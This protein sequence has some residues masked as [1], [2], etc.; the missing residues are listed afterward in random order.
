VTTTPRIYDAAVAQRA[1]ANALSTPRVDAP[2]VRVA[3]V[4]APCLADDARVMCA[5]AHSLACASCVFRRRYLIAYL[6]PA[7]GAALAQRLSRDAILPYGCVAAT[8]AAAHA[9][10]NAPRLEH[11]R[12]AYAL[13]SCSTLFAWPITPSHRALALNRC[14]LPAGEAKQR[15]VGICTCAAPA[16]AAERDNTVPLTLTLYAETR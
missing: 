9:L 16:G 12:C 13:T 1:L 7:R 5:R 8:S 4:C 11:R 3:V 10:M 6:W 2:R 15:A 14:I